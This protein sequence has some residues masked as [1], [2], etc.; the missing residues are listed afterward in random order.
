MNNNTT[1]LKTSIKK[2]GIALSLFTG[3]VSCIQIPKTVEF[4]ESLPFTEIDGYKFHTEIFGS[5]NSDTIIVVHGGPGADYEYLKPLKALSKNFRVIFY[6]QRGN[7]LSPRVDSNQLTVESNVNDLHSIIEYFSENKKIKLI[8][9]SWGGM[10]VT[11]YLSAYPENV[12]QAVIVEPGMLYPESAKAFVAEIKKSQSLGDIFALIKHLLVYPLVSQHDKHEGYDYVMTK[13]LNRNKPGAPY[14]C[15]GQVMPSNIFNRGG[16]EAFNNMLKPIMDDPKY[17]TYDLTEGVSKYQG[18][19]ML[20]SSSCSLFG[21]DF[22]EK[23]HISK[24]PNQTIH[25][26]ANNMGHN[27]LTLNPEWSLK[28]LSDFFKLTEV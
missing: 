23:Y 16:Y 26:L 13:L 7:G 19:L 24:L 6:D 21:Y 12:S 17:F 1:Y 27:M 10:L 18:D 4:D 2:L 25:M 14:Q 8:G 11:A 28:V 22:Q 3:L 20:I 15:D 9:H 5:E